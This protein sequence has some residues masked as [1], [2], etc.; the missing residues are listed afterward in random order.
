MEGVNP[1]G[2]EIGSGTYGRVFEVDYEGTLCIAKELHE[3]MAQSLDEE[4]FLNY[5]H[6]MSTIHHPHI[7]QFLGLMAKYALLI[8]TYTL[9]ISL[10]GVYYS[11]RE[12]SILPV[13]VMEKMQQSLR[14]LVEKFV[15][16]PWNVKLSILN[17]VSL[18]LR[19]LHSKNPPIVHCDLTPNNVLLGGYLEAK[20]TDIGIAKLLNNDNRTS[21]N[22][23]LPF[24]PV[25][26]LGESPIYTPAFDVFSFGGVILYVITQLWPELNNQTQSDDDVKKWREMP[27][28]MRRNYLLDNMV[29]DAADLKPLVVSC[30]DVNPDNRPSV[31]QISAVI[32][33]AKEK[34]N[35]KYSDDEKNPI[36]W[37][38]Q[39]SREQQSQ[40]RQQH[41]QQQQQHQ[42]QQVC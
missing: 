28:D 18:G 1:T 15:N 29:G 33:D 36:V 14:N 31:V 37:S 22:A 40:E 3:H 30:L 17:D 25:E 4:T 7:I 35:V 13:M 38:A 23:M 21:V 41:H 27:M 24:M 42:Q 32:K 34:Y 8:V 26:T 39:V 5:C 9:Y 6:I 19:Y 10:T 20:I 2:I 11:D 12:Q 16:I